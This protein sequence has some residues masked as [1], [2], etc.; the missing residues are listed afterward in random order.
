M[1][2]VKDEELIGFGDNSADT[3]NADK[4]PKKSGGFQCM[5]LSFSILKGITKKGYKVPTPIQRKTIPLV[6]EGRDVVAMART[7]SGKTACFLLPMFEKLKTH[8]TK[9]GIRAII[10]SPTRELA[11][12]TLKFLKEL[13][14]FTG[15]RSIVLLGG[16]SM[17]TQFS[18]IHEKP[19]IVVA[20]P[21]RFLH[22]CVEMDLSLKNVQYIVFDEADRLFEMGFGEQLNEIVQ[23]L[24][25]NRQTLLFSAT[26][27]K[28]LVEFA[29]AGLSD[30]VLIRLDVESKI[31]ET[32]QLSFVSCRLEEKPAALLC[33]MNHVIPKTAT[34]IIFAATKHHVEYL[35]AMLRENG[36]P[37]T[38]IYSD[39]HPSAR[40]INVAKFQNAQVKV[41]IVTDVAARGIDIPHLDYVINYNFPAKV[42]LFVHRVGRCARAGREGHAICLVSGDELCYMLDLLLFLGRPLLLAGTD[43]ESNKDSKNVSLGRI[44]LDYLDPQLSSLNA[45]HSSGSELD[46][47][48]KV[49]EN[50]Y[51]RYIQCRSGAS[52]ES[53]R[54]A[55]E[56]S[57][58]HIGDSS[59]FDGKEVAGKSQILT[60][61]KNYRPNG[62]VFEIGVSS[63]SELYTVMKATRRKHKNNIVSFH[64]KVQEILESK[65]ATSEK[66]EINLEQSGNDDIAT[67]FSQVISG[68]RKRE[69]FLGNSKKQCTIDKENFIPYKPS[70]QAI[71]KELAVN[72]FT[73]EANAV[74]VDLTGD[75]EA[76]MLG[77]TKQRKV[78]D[79][80][81]KRIVT[82]GG[83]KKE[84]RIKSESGAWIPA[85]YK[86][87]RYAG[88]LEKTKTLSRIE[89][90][91]EDEGPVQ[92][93]K[94]KIPHTRWANHNLKVEMKKKLELKKPEQIAKAREQLERKQRRH[95]RHKKKGR[96]KH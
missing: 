30:P 29:R 11:L 18:A 33:L 94:R 55:K 79:K 9:S 60:G 20:T 71:E 63:N 2:L 72:N 25:E 82:V 19:D 65:K 58:L 75:T 22:I 4:R 64:Q 92:N 93:I 69:P 88:W 34:T 45:A 53:V 61:I 86:S 77:A 15:L 57:L 5:G 44:P 14:K 39:L 91:Q 12:Q 1:A 49:S 51:K 42:K 84:G 81:K 90:E 36:I 13:G 32:L 66:P 52:M 85:S 31:P 87:G 56:V 35:H 73:R 46:S 78:W 21:G 47:L 68:K 17:E 24:P 6:V 70:D 28:V 50:A 43:S 38:Y 67:T 10:L 95:G 8:C 62:T 40:K 27:P 76:G 74:G 80:K 59:L 89:E 7:G 3:N 48:R 41:L 83:Q 16:D 23:R 54:R 26:L 37:N 96:R